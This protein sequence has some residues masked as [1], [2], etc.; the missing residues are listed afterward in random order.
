MSTQHSLSKQK[1]AP[2]SSVPSALERGGGLLRRSRAS[3][4]TTH[5]ATRRISSGTLAV[6]SNSNGGSWR[7]A[8]ALCAG[9]SGLS[10]AR[11]A[12]TGCGILATRGGRVGTTAFRRKVAVGGASTSY[13]L[14]PSQPCRRRHSGLMRVCVR[15]VAPPRAA[16]G[17]ARNRASTTDFISKSG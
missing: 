11:V 4:A 6:V 13:W 14:T 17:A 2:A 9:C 5:I 1:L 15:V 3:F 12:L 8:E 16:A 7:R 10:M